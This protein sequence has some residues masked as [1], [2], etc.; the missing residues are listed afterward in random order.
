[1]LSGKLGISGAP[2]KAVSGALRPSSITDLAATH[3]DK[4]KRRLGLLAQTS[5]AYDFLCERRA[6]R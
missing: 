4:R 3:R 5:Q 6:R 2:G 1:M